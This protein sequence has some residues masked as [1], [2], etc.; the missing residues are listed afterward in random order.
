MPPLLCVDL[1]HCERQAAALAAE[2]AGHVALVEGELLAEHY[3]D[4][5]AAEVDEEL[6][7]AG[8]VSF[9]EL[10]RRHGLSAEQVTAALSAR[11]GRCVHG[12]VEGGLLYTDAH[13]ARLAAQLRGA[14]RATASPCGVQELTASAFEGSAEAG[15]YG[16]IAGSLIAELVAAG[17]AHGT[18]RSGGLLWTPTVHA[19]RQRDA[20]SAFYVANGVLSYDDAVRIGVTQPRA[21]LTAQHPDGV[22]LD[23]AMVSPAFLE[24]V[25]AA[26]EE[27]L[28]EAGWADVA[29]HLPPPLSAV[30]ARAVA[31]HS[32]VVTGAI[33]TGGVLLADCRIIGEPF[34]TAAAELARE[35]GRAA[36]A[37]AAARRKA[38]TPPAAAA[39]ATAAGGGALGRGGAGRRA[40]PDVSHEDDEDD[41][42][43]GPRGKGKGF[44]SGKGARGKPAGT[45][46]D[47]AVDAPSSDA[48]APGVQELRLQLQ[49]AHE[50][51]AQA[52]DGELSS[53]LAEHV[54]CAAL[55]AFS[56]AQRAALSQGAEER[57]RRLDALTRR[58]DEAYAHLLLLAKGAELFAS[59]D[60]V[61]PLLAKQLLRSPG[62]DVA[63]ALLQLLHEEGGAGDSAAVGA[64]AALSD[65]QRAALARGLPAELRPAGAALLEALA[66]RS[67]AA[68]QASLEPLA[69]ACGV[70]LKPLDKKAERAMLLAHRTALT[71]QLE[72]E[73]AAPVALQVAVP[74]LYASR[75]GVALSV[76]GR[77]LGA[78]VAR[79]GEHVSPAEMEVLTVFHEAV[80]EL[81]QLR[82]KD[83]P[84]A[85]AAADEKQQA[86][87]EQLP[88]LQALA[89]RRDA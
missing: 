58:A 11:L 45:S 64:A 21:W 25:D 65:A 62:A 88:A 54:H 55:A 81:L 52:A 79:L 82:G 41:W 68:L 36:G 66:G 10:A 37:A 39:S 33:K 34:L 27:A 44:K 6:R 61:A 1:V 9:A 74:L 40:G 77:A 16:G 63:D 4:A 30:D 43:T 89:T 18:L 78:V 15:S 73:T 47:A 86:L 3:W 46:R 49:R 13:V 31:A 71:A 70:R 5:L 56:E 83:T 76:P 7:S 72:A 23:T 84:E 32:R 24:Q 80:V 14:L 26:L 75:R 67:V 60:A 50:T 22:H 2:S 8:S 42:S 28:A 59:D 38:S 17:A 20:A 19:R 35:L 87:A 57:R 12:R 51:L 53:A 29:A 85:R 48:S 69:S